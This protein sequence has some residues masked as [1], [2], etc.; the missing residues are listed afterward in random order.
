MRIRSIFIPSKLFT[1]E[2]QYLQHFP[3]TSNFSNDIFGTRRKHQF[4]ALPVASLAAV[5]TSL[6]NNC[7]KTIAI[8]RGHEQLLGLS[9][10]LIAWRR[11]VIGR[12]VDK[13]ELI[14]APVRTSN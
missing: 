6:E 13:Q 3:T 10:T 9:T 12:S 2:A 14:G 4:S 7:F 5:D 11:P 8:S 1:H